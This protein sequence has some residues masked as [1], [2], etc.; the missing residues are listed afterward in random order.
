[1]AIFV[2]S[3]GGWGTG[4]SAL[5]DAFAQAPM[6]RARMR[7]MEL[8]AA[9]TAAANAR[10]QAELDLRRKEF[11]HKQRM[12]PMEQQ[13]MQGQVTGQGL[14]NRGREQDYQFNEQNNPLLL[15]KGTAEAETAETGAGIAKRR[16][17]AYDPLMGAATDQV[18]TNLA[19]AVVPKLRGPAMLQDAPTPEGDSAISALLG[20]A[21]IANEVDAVRPRVEGLSQSLIFQDTPDPNKWIEDTT[22]S[23]VEGFDAPVSG[24]TES[25][26][27]GTGPEASAYQIMQA[28]VQK[29]NAGLPTTPEEDLAYSLAYNRAF[30]DKTEI[31][32][33]PVTGADIAVTVK[34]SPPAGFPMPG[35]AAQPAPAPTPSA[36]PPTPGAPVAPETAAAAPGPQP[37]PAPVQPQ[38]N[39]TQRPVS[40][41]PPQQMDQ[42]DNQN[43]FRAVLMSAPLGRLI[44]AGGYD[45]VTGQVHGNAPTWWDQALASNDITAWASSDAAKGFVSDSFKAL[46]P[47][48][49]M[50]TGAAL[51]PTELPR[52]LNAWLPKSSDPP[53]L[54]AQKYEDLIAAQAMFENLS[55]DRR[56]VQ[57]ISSNDPAMLMAAR[58]MYL[59][60]VAEN[61]GLGKTLSGA[62]NATPAYPAAPA[63]A[64]AA[65]AAGGLPDV[66]TMSDEQLKALIN[67]P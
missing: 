39:V 27:T 58:D 17:G 47:I 50:T 26:W 42:A 7:Q 1:M 64:P 44:Q 63:P 35:A 29:K 66:S 40:G 10:A 18:M 31:R 55:S 46:D 2:P 25:Q 8:D 54:R 19:D 3:G 59:A 43:R 60:K 5:A 38:G 36:L 4:L 52:Y 67:G 21:R 45:P 24:D 51:N 28:Y 48:V 11:E 53:E 41:I 57:L 62:P 23:M 61:P 33:D 9:N 14:E 34:A 16:A 13:L 15:R 32:K 65:P 49:R 12:F 30:A 56:F 20:R 37:V 22:K 6:N